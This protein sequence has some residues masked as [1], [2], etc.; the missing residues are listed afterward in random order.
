MA[1]RI[2]YLSIEEISPGMTLGAAL[3]VG[4]H[5][6]TTFALP[7]GHV[8]TESNLVQMNQRHAEWACIAEDDPRS[9]EER[10]EALQAVREHQDKLFARADRSQPAMA[11]LYDAVLRYRSL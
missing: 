10:A 11:A 7:A 3:N 1:T 8:L 4:D 2:R 5:G 9:D 6:V